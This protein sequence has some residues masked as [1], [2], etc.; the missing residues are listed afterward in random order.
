MASYRQI[1][2]CIWKDAWFFDLSAEHKL[3]W[4]Y[5]FSNE[6][7]NLTGLYDIH[8]RIIAFETGLAMETIDAGFE[9]FAEAGKAFYEDGWAWVPNLI[10]Y[11]AGSLN[12]SKIR[13]HIVG[14]LAK[15]ADTPLKAR[16]IEHYNSI[17]D[18]EYRIDT[19]SIGY[20]TGYAEHEQEHEQE[21]EHKGADAPAVPVTFEQWRQGYRDA[22]NQNG[23]AGYMLTTLYPNYYNGAVTPNYGMLGKL[24]NANDAEYVLSLFFQHSSR[25]PS[26]DPI[27]F[28]QGILNRRPKGAGAPARKQQFDVVGDPA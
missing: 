10:K 19:L 25:P 9:A 22:D 7:A 11:N 16:C 15:I 12:S 20:P 6:R 13:T 1:H 18:E 28:I 4:I 5:L 27:K 2:T 24:L 26:G 3:L 14:A 21:H 8:K 23:Y 17:V